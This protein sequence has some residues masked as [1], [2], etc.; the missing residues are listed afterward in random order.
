M[1][2]LISNTSL[3]KFYLA[4]TIVEDT[5]SMFCLIVFIYAGFKIRKNPSKFIIA[6]WALFFLNVLFYT[7]YEFTYPITNSKTK[8][9]IGST[10]NMFQILALWTF[11]LHYYNSAVNATKILLEGIHN[12]SESPS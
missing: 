12:Y 8:D 7:I 4:D 6:V 9:L 2:D 1:Q 10:F 3:D 11:S 5:C